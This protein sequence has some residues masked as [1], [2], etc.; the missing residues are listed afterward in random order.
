MSINLVAVLGAYAH[1]YSIDCG[2]PDCAAVRGHLDAHEAAGDDADLAAELDAASEDD[3]IYTA[4]A[5][6]SREVYDA[7]AARSTRDD[8][9]LY[10]ERLPADD[11]DPFT[12]R[13]TAQGR[14]VPSAESSRGSRGPHGPRVL[15]TLPHVSTPV[16]RPWCA[17]PHLRYG[18]CDCTV[19]DARVS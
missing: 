8:G 19:R 18:W 15:F 13:I 12:P 3:D 14:P 1:L 9:A 17:T 2:C 11:A 16:H 4:I 10:H 6:A 7:D 5:D